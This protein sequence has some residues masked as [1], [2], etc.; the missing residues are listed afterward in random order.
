MPMGEMG[1]VQTDWHPGW[2]VLP[3]SP[4][5]KSRIQGSPGLS[6][7][8]VVRTRSPAKPPLP[9]PWARR[10][11]AAI[12]RGE[13]HE[14][15]D[16]LFHFR[17]ICSCCA[18]PVAQDDASPGSERE[19]RNVGLCSKGTFV[20]PGRTSQ[21]CLWKVRGVNRDPSGDPWLGKL[22]LC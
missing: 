12:Q 8:V 13:D 1:D 3:S 22:L 19:G 10:M 6:P 2:D 21:D 15:E 5:Q 7:E 16:A 20:Q 9:K 11:P 14:L 17:A 4:S 18:R